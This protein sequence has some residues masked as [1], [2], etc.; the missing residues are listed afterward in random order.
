MADRMTREQRH[1]CMSRIRGKDTG[2]EILVRK[3]LFADGFRFRV[4]VASLPGTPD[5]VLKKYSTAVFVNGCFW[6]G[7]ENCRLYSI[8][9][10]NTA[11]WKEKVA[12]NRRRDAAVIQRLQARGWKTVTV[13]ECE[14]DSRHLSDTVR[15]LED[16]I[17]LNGQERLAEIEEMKLR[18][19]RIRTENRLHKSKEENHASEVYS[20]Y[21]IPVRVR[22]E[23]RLHEDDSF[24]AES[25]PEQ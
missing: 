7:H 11:F 17:R 15:R 13:W 25:F 2:P 8:P 19:L 10:S 20:R 4:N 5:I 12:R 6:H 21:R 9:K 16:Q 22:K 18:T 1:L 23:A 24:Q 3:A 14:L